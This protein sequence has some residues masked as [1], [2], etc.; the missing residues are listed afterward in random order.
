[1]SS[2]GKFSEEGKARLLD[3]DGGSLK[4]KVSSKGK[5]GKLEKS[6]S[7]TPSGVKAGVTSGDKDSEAVSKFSRVLFLCL[8]SCSVYRRA[9][10][11]RTPS[12]IK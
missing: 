3:D 9:P 4:I 5:G 2:K 6:G 7:D 11:Q 12:K 1:M 10:S 8:V